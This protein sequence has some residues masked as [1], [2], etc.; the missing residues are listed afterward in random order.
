MKIFKLIFFSLIIICLSY[1]TCF[2]LPKRYNIDEEIIKDNDKWEYRITLKNTSDPG[3]NIYDF[4][5]ST[6]EEINFF[7]TNIYGP[8]NWGFISGSQ[9]INW[10]SS[11]KLYDIPPGEFRVF[12]FIMSEEIPQMTQS[13]AVLFTEPTPIPE[14]ATILLIGSGLAGVGLLRRK[15]KNI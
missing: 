2:S 12:G 3:Y 15:K 6:D 7:E 11:G 14:P 5:K 1:G 13:F 4:F 10:Y 9:F 8:G